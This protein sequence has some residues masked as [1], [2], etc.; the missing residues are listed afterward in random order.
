M[1]EQSNTPSNTQHTLS[2]LRAVC[3][4]DVCPDSIQAPDPF[5]VLWPPDDHFPKPK[6]KPKT[7]PKTKLGGAFRLSDFGQVQMALP[8]SVPML[9]M[10]PGMAGSILS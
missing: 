8:V 1:H 5:S 4:R 2:M 10:T 9:L 3:A 7:K 6:P